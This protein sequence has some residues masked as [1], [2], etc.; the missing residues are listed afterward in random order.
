[1]EGESVGE[2]EARAGQLRQLRQLDG[3]EAKVPSSEPSE[4]RSLEVSRVLESIPVLDSARSSWPEATRSRKTS[5]QSAEPYSLQVTFRLLLG[6]H[7][8]SALQ[9]LN[10]EKK[11]ETQTKELESLRASQIFEASSVSEGLS[12]WGSEA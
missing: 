10:P 1:M 12:C 5:L 6:V 8:P 11:Q 3:R 9:L 4:P 7:L 2:M